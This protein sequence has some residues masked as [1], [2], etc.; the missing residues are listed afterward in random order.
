MATSLNKYHSH[1]SRPGFT[2]WLSQSFRRQRCPI[3]DGDESG[4]VVG[5]PGRRVL[6]S[7]R[8]VRRAAPP[9]DTLAQTQA[10][11][12]VHDQRLRLGTFHSDTS[13]A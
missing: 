4:P 11:I 5:I 10:L 12:V 3:A 2:L 8:F 1:A 6:R 9:S 13:C 7:L